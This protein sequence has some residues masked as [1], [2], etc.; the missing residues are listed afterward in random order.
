MCIVP[1]DIFEPISMM[2]SNSNS[3]NESSAAAGTGAGG[4]N[5]YDLEPIPFGGGVK[6]TNNSTTA[7]F[8][9]NTMFSPNMTSMTMIVQ[10]QSIEVP[11]PTP[12][13]SFSS[14]SSAR[15]GASSFSEPSSQA[16]N[17][18]ANDKLPYRNQNNL[19]GTKT[20]SQQQ[21]FITADC[22]FS[23]SSTNNNMMGKFNHMSG[24]SNAST[25]TL[26]AAVSSSTSEERISNEQQDRWQQLLND[27]IQFKMD[28]GS[29]CVPTYWPQNVS[30][31]IYH[32]CVSIGSKV[33]LI[34][35]VY[36]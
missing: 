13:T 35:S 17:K 6:E 36:R 15:V 31:S 22:T 5:S 24:S 1:F 18:T 12:I 3:N 34:D 30:K 20:M 23:T 11:C 33:I 27:L 32:S 28:Y 14:P 9:N 10:Q 26:P 19:K 7:S 25:S 16:S 8:F 4:F 21:Q 2:S 29:C